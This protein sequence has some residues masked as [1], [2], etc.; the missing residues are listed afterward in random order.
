M[1]FPTYDLTLHKTYYEK[2]FFNL[3]VSV[4]KY[5]RP[6]SGE[7]KLFLGSSK[8]ILTGKVN[9]EANLNGTP[10]IHGGSELRD[11]FFKNFKMKDQ[12]VVTV[13]APTEIQIG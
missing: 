13:L 6:Q 1:T 7:V 11:W 9:R 5:V 8:R 3:G 12:V 2:G 10:R 4:D